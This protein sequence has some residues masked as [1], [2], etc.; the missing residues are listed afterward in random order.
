MHDSFVGPPK[1]MEYE[2]EHNVGRK[3][4]S[5]II[6]WGKG[7]IDATPAFAWAV[8][9]DLHVVLSWCARKG[10]SWERSARSKR[11]KMPLPCNR[12]MVQM[13]LFS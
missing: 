3:K 11:G 5:R 2:I 6:V 13:E 12:K 8:N 9:K 7:V 4:A 10:L 1:P